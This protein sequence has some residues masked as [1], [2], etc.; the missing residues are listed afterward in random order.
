[1]TSSYLKLVPKAATKSWRRY[2]RKAIELRRIAGIQM[3][4]K[5]NPVELADKFQFRVLFPEMLNGLSE[6]AILNLKATSGWSG[7][8]TKK[9]PDGSRIIFLNQKESLERRA[10]TLMEEVCHILLD[11]G[12]SLIGADLVSC[13]SYNLRVEQEAYGVGTA[14]LVP[15]YC[16]ES[17]LLGGHSVIQTAKH[18]GV[19]VSVI[20]YRVK[21]LNLASILAI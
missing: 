7:G 20:L 13:R 3:E 8:A 16:L 6:K 21:G 12:P 9:L 11:H 4:R 10:A 18:F 14:I 2:E 15:Y 1:M 17:K 19:T 5:I